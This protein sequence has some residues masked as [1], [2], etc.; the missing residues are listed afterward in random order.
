M[1]K[2]PDLPSERATEI[3]QDRQGSYGHPWDVYKMLA[4]TCE[5]MQLESTDPYHQVISMIL[6]KL[7]RERINPHAREDNIDD[8]AGYA[9]VYRM[10]ETR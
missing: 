7:I 3:V 5:A 6:L 8:V 1:P 2:A 9:N 4:D 10:M